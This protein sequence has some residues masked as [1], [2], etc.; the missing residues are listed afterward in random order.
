L[1]PQVNLEAQRIEMFH[2]SAAMGQKWA[3]ICHEFT[4]RIR[5]FGP[6]PVRTALENQ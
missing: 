3:E 5:E 1:L 2:L 4:E 6:S